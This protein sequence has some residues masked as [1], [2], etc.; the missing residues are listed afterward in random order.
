MPAYSLVNGVLPD[1][2]L[3]EGDT[4]YVRGYVDVLSAGALKLDVNST[5]GLRLWIDGNEIE[6]LNAVISSTRGRKTLTFSIDRKHRGNTGLR[7]LLVA[8]DKSVRFKPEGGI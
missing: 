8:A 4:I 7:V 6:D 2:D 5:K 3:G 1:G